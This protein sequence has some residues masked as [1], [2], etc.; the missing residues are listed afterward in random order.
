MTENF[1]AP[2]NIKKA[3]NG[4]AL[5]LIVF[6]ILG[7]VG[8]LSLVVDLSREEISI[9]DLQIAAEAASL[10]GAKSL[11]G[12]ELG[13]RNAKRAV[14]A[15]LKQNTIYGSLTRLN[16]DNNPQIRFDIGE[17]IDEYERINNS[18]P[19]YHYHQ[20]RIGNL[21]VK[22][23]R[24]VYWH[25]S[26]PN[27]DNP[28]GYL[29]TGLE[30]QPL[31]TS[32]VSESRPMILNVPVHLLANAVKVTITLDSLAT[33]FG[34]VLKQ[35][36]FDDLSRS[37][38]AVFD[39]RTSECVVPIAIPAC[40]LLLDTDPNNSENY[41]VQKFDASAQCERET[42]ATE[43]NPYSG[44]S[45][46]FFENVEAKIEGRL[47]SASYPLLPDAKY[48]GGENTCFD[49]GLKGRRP[50]C[51]AIP[52]NAM[53]GTVS[54]TPSTDPA[55][56]NDVISQFQANGGCVNARL[57]DYFRPLEGDGW[58][59]DGTATSQ[60]SA[61]LKNFLENG[62][63]LTTFANAFIVPETDMPSKNYPH[64]RSK[65][66]K[67]I[68]VTALN[69]RPLG[70]L[71]GRIKRRKQ[72]YGT[73]SDENSGLRI[74]WPVAGALN[75]TAALI[76]A[77]LNE[78]G[79]DN[80]T[81]PMCHDRELPSSYINNPNAPV[82]EVFVMVI[83]PE[84]QANNPVN[85]C[86]Y[87]SLFNFEEQAAQAPSVSNRPRIVGFVRANIFDFNVRSLEDFYYQL[88]Y[89]HEGVGDIFSAAYWDPAIPNDHT[90]PRFVES[91]SPADVTNALLADDQIITFDRN[92]WQIDIENS[93]EGADD[94]LDRV[95]TFIE[96][97]DEFIRCTQT[98]KGDEDGD[99]E[100][101]KC[102]R[103]GKKDDA[104]DDDPLS[105]PELSVAP[106]LVN[107][108]GECFNVGEGV[109][110]TNLGEAFQQFLE[111]W[112]AFVESA[113]DCVIALKPRNVDDTEPKIGHINIRPGVSFS[114][115]TTTGCWDK[116][117]R[118]G[119]NADYGYRVTDVARD[120]ADAMEF[121]IEAFG[122]GKPG[123]NCLPYKFDGEFPA[124]SPSSWQTLEA[125][126]SGSGCGGVRLRLSCDDKSV[127]PTGYP[128]DGPNG[129]QA[130][131]VE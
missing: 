58:L 94:F 127:I 110:F 101:N 82:Q 24:G 63:N 100:D 118:P 52:L 70:Q 45:R 99:G 111:D 62:P 61:T 114:S 49:S 34:R 71:H 6:I 105:P 13:W 54:E 36:S 64:L 53:L 128:V 60:M 69:Y 104:D 25:S 21:L 27:N 124:N 7:I 10:A 55:Q 120:L 4:L 30:E 129:A 125:R 75:D 32:G 11:D 47:R 65:R 29:F 57:G 44:G 50:N 117:I 46:S 23:E 40:A 17:V 72:E 98:C 43:S 121:A 83:A 59:R 103:C 33:T 3:E 31:Q 18:S 37:A 79:A 41:N 38:I 108:L 76:M 80:W 109:D 102:K 91:G 20:G 122:T 14:I 42:V 96:N 35:N 88:G 2:K 78:E 8:V 28:A 67:R 12:T 85:Y 123:M 56:A 84:G 86:D 19:R 126:R 115:T 81:N 113:G 116:K 92:P 106:E 95:L 130:A 26:E 73:Q 107:A 66:P 5:L 1:Q 9:D 22:M 15:A 97:Y 131:L 48:R 89:H 87:E 93:I 77:D 90:N 68:P 51:K 74:S 119:R 16:P 112:S 39:T